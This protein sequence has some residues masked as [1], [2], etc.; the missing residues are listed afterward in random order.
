MQ[1]ISMVD[2]TTRLAN[3]VL[4]QYDIVVAIATG[5]LTPG[6]LVANKLGCDLATIAI[7][8]RD[9]SNKPMFENARLKSKVELPCNIKRILLVDEVVVS[10][11]T[12]EVAKN[13]LA[14]YD[15]D[16]LAFKGQ[17]DYVLF[18][19]IKECVKWPWR[20]YD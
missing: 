10:G 1:E 7:E 20:I 18:P 13:E 4:D 2:V 5:G 17:A 15:V 14:A 16:T 9:D 19:E 6:A 8:F 11:S 3:L 12:L